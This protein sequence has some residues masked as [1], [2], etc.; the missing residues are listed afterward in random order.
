M[1][2]KLD[3][4]LYPTA[5]AL[6]LSLSDYDSDASSAMMSMDE[7]VTEP[8]AS[9]KL[10]DATNMSRPVSYIHLSGLNSVITL[11]IFD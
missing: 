10:S 2:R 9:E 4:T 1:V 3:L 5:R 7:L 6:T 11:G 8:D